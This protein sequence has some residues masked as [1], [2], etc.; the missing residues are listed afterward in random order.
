[1][2]TNK[3][4]DV[5]PEFG[6]PLETF[7]LILKTEGFETSV[8]IRL[9]IY[10]ILNKFRST[11]MTDLSKLK[12]LLSPILV[13]NKMQQEK[14]DQIFLAY[15]SKIK[16]DST[17]ISKDLQI[18]KSKIKSLKSIMFVL[19]FVIAFLTISMIVIN[20]NGN[21]SPT[22]NT[23]GFVLPPV[24]IKYPIFA[25]MYAM[26]SIAIVLIILRYK[27]LNINHPQK[28][29]NLDKTNFSNKPPYTLDFPFQNHLITN[30]KILFDFAN[31]MRKR[32]LSDI[33]HLDIGKSIYKTIKTGGFPVL[34][35]KQLTK[36]PD[37]LILIDNENNFKLY[38]KLFK[39]L[40]DTLKN[41]DVNIELFTYNKDIRI[42]ND[43]GNNIITLDELYQKFPQ[44]DLIIFGNAEHFI[45][46]RTGFIDDWSEKQIGQWNRKVIV[47]PKKMEKWDY[48]E[49]VLSQKLCLIPANMN[50]LLQ[51]VEVLNNP[52]NNVFFDS[53]FSELKYNENLEKWKMAISVTNDLNWHILLAIG[54]AIEKTQ[55]NKEKLVT[56]DNLLYLT[57]TKTFNRSTWSSKKRSKRLIS[58]KENPKI[59]IAARQAVIEL[60]QKCA[61]P[62]N[63]YANAE[64]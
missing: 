13:K 22:P 64:K 26:I 43:S 17:D 41:E 33:N 14:F 20:W 23:G 30:Q 7:I 50:S 2:I 32:Q 31:I 46:K 52:E 61:P 53:G 3:N 48:D 12:P 34:H 24:L 47:S 6:I 10:E 40:I 42:C 57:Q 15:Y 28:K 37:Y 62:E 16:E 25:I 63:S 21:D 55:V 49:Y 45:S 27:H 4:M 35:F 58:L 59:E 36:Q 18:I 44:H 1:M 51:L 11:W 56:Y 9:K 8:D 39:Y 54:S 5:D 60:Y 38:S 29:E 19:V